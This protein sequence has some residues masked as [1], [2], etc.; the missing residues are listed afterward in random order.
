MK[1]FFS[2]SLA[3]RGWEITTNGEK[4]IDS[5][6]NQNPPLESKLV[7]NVIEKSRAIRWRLYLFFSDIYLQ[8]L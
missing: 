8:T 4:T 3:A 5:N 6:Y 2:T 1:I 7:D